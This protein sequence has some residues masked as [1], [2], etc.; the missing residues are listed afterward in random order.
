MTLQQGVSC[1]YA[2]CVYACSPEHLR[3]V[4][5]LSVSMHAA[6]GLCALWS[7]SRQYLRQIAAG[8]AELLRDVAFFDAAF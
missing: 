4:C 1:M 5:M 2:Q 6:P 3:I 7:R 8:G